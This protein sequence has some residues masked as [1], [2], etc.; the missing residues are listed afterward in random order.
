MTTDDYLMYVMIEIASKLKNCPEG[1][2]LWTEMFGEVSLIEVT[3]ESDVM[4]R[5]K[6]DGDWSLD[7]Y[8]RYCAEADCVLWPASGESW[9]DFTGNLLWSPE[10]LRPYDKVLVLH[11]KLWMPELLSGYCDGKFYLIGYGYKVFQKVIPYCD[12]TKDLAWTSE[13]PGPGWKTW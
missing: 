13:I 9:E 4:I 12:E 2:K 10:N 7:R 1:M 5:T 6:N 11:D 3:P 8:G